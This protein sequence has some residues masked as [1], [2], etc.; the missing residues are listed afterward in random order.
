MEAARFALDHQVDIR[1]EGGRVISEP[2][3]EPVFRLKD[4]LA[5]VTDENI[6]GEIDFGAP[7]GQESV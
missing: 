7:V 6:H 4:L 3:A 5:A 1:E 2:I